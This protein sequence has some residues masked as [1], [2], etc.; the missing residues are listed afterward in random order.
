MCKSKE[1]EICFYRGGKVDNDKRTNVRKSPKPAL[2][3][4]KISSILVLSVYNGLLITHQCSMQ[5]ITPFTLITLNKGTNVGKSPT[6][7]LTMGKI[8]NL[9]NNL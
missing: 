6:L 1:F 3:M 2:T 5:D 8:I 9:F 4:G 7:A